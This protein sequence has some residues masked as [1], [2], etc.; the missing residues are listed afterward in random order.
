M[1]LSLK[2]LRLCFGSKEEIKM[3]EEELKQKTFTTEV[4]DGSEKTEEKEV[5]NPLKM[6]W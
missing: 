4:E 2:I 5:F 6:G 1:I 3:N